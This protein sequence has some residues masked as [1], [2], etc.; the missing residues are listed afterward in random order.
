MIIQGIV[1]DCLKC[2]FTNYVCAI[3]LCYFIYIDFSSQDAKNY[4]G[5]LEKTDNSEAITIEEEKED[6]KKKKDEENVS[7]D[8]SI[9]HVTDENLLHPNQNGQHSSPGLVNVIPATSS[10]MV[11][12]V[13][14]SS[15]K[16]NGSDGS[17]SNAKISVVGTETHIP[18][19]ETLSSI[20]A[21][22]SV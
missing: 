15:S 5:N 9:P 21:G 3:F 2:K 6:D 12:T 4:A 7:L 13:P 16:L 19:S 14:E 22:N 8:K 20:L 10:V 11:S 1:H 18:P 17:S